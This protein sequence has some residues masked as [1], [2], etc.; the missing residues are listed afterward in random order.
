[1]RRIWLV[2]LALALAGCSGPLISKKPLFEPGTSRMKPGLWAL[3][4]KDCRRPADDRLFDWPSCA[5]PARVRDDDITVFSPQGPVTLKMVGAGD[6]PMILQVQLDGDLLAQGA[7]SLFRDWP[8]EKPT[9]QVPIE[10][11]YAYFS[12]QS[13]E[14]SPFAGGMLTLLECPSDD[15]PGIYVPPPKET[16][17]KDGSTTTEYD[18]KCEARTAA[19]VRAVAKSALSEWPTW[20]AVWIAELPDRSLLDDAAPAKE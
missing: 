16:K 2:G 4:D 5:K 6:G 9:V 17:A 18:E 13:G 19:G 10:P 3:L 12:F 14:P 20:R 8:M 11:I 1:M 15:V 7:A